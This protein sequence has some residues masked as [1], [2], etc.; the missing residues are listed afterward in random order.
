MK[1]DSETVLLSS[2]YLAPIEYYA[3]LSKGY[4]IILDTDE[5]YVK[6]SYRNRMVIAGANGPLTL[7][8]PIE[9]P[10]R[11]KSQMKDIRISEHGNWRH[12]H[13]NAIISAYRSSPFFQYFEDDFRPLYE[14]KHLFLHQFNEQL[15]TLV[16]Q[17][18]GIETKVSY[19]R[20]FIN[21]TGE[22]VI[23][24][25]ETIHPKYPSNYRTEPYYQ[26]FAGKLGFIQNLS[27]ID[28]LFNVGN[29]ARLYLL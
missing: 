23:D 29:E 6:Q 1:T 10:E 4:K 5:S 15:R 22:E 25:R 17:L 12:L 13:W 16:C 8:I 2:L 27:I 19:S 3:V 24:L 14:T 18:L 9:K 21:Y 26:V 11:G 7:S 20:D 28:L